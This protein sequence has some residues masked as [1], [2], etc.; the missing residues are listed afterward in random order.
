MAGPSPG[1][2]IAS[3]RTDVQWHSPSERQI[4][5]TQG[6]NEGSRRHALG[7]WDVPAPEGD[8]PHQRERDGDGGQCGQ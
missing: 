6:R 8:E 2:T 7:A 3:S 4:V 1:S 5:I